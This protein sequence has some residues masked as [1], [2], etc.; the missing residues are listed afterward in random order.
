MK[1]SGT[2]FKIIKV[3]QENLDVNYIYILTYERGI[4]STE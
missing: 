1:K 2:K 4:I 3:K